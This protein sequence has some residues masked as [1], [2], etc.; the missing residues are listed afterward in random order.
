[1][2]FKIF[3]EILELFIKCNIYFFIYIIIYYFSNNKNYFQ[4]RYNLLLSFTKFLQNKNV[5]YLKIFQTLCIN[6][7]I[8]TDN[9]FKLLIKFTDNVPY[10]D[11]DIDYNL[12]ESIKN[13]DKNLTINNKVINSGIVAVVFK[14]K[15]NKTNIV[16]KLMKKNIK[17]KIY[18][19]FD[20][21]EFFAN[22]TQY[23]PII[24]NFNIKKILIDNKNIILNQIDFK[25]EC[26]NI[27]DFKNCYK[28]LKEYIIPHVYKHFTDQYSNILI[29]DD[30]SGLKFNDLD[31]LS[32]DDKFNFAKIYIK[33]G[34]LGLFLFSKIHSDLHVGNLFF[35]IDNNDDIKY[36]IGIIDFGICS[37]PSKENQNIYWCFFNDIL[38]KNNYN[39]LLEIIPNVIE[40]PME[41]SKLKNKDK[42]KLVEI[43]SVSLE[44][45]KKIQNSFSAAKDLSLILK[46]YNLVFSKELNQLILGLAIV[47]NFC[48][49]LTDDVIDVQ[50]KVLQEFDDFTNMTNID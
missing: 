11:R 12:I 16:V 9:E 15:Y 32:I 49:Y 42:L 36:K 6:K 8:L 19:I 46:K 29:M 14:G 31:K 47:H 20:V 41:F 50:N 40:N 37:F 24:C 30:I 5:L 10:Q 35:Y 3:C 33:F 26:N 27:I 7:D 17:Q 2:K 23:I 38:F 39:K 43:I 13:Y 48:N 45:N 18:E 4:N 21:L 22:L 44:F 34:Y 25:K 1:M 28:N